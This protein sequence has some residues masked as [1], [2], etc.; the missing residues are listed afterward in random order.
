[1]TNIKRRHLKMRKHYIALVQA[2][3]SAC[4]VSFPDF[5]GLVTAARTIDAAVERA[6]EALARHVEDMLKDGETIPPPCSFEDVKKFAPNY[7]DVML[8]L[9]PLLPPSP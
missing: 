2:G 5:P 9:V 7:R 3:P 4:S 6:G 1:M 8:V